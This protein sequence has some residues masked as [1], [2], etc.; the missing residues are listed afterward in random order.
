LPDTT[1]ASGSVFGGQ[2][3]LQWKD[4]DWERKTIHIRRQL[5]RL[6]GGGFEFSTPKTKA[7]IRKIKVGDQVIAVLKEQRGRIA[8]TAM[9]LMKD[10]QEFG[11][12][13]PARA[14]KPLS[15]R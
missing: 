15:Q 3:S 13:F 8:V 11:L 12:V 7:G 4:I 1:I 6:Y 14:G 10:W 2:V 9:D 5:K